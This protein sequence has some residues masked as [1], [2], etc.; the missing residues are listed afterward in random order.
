MK[1]LEGGSYR[2]TED[3]QIELADRAGKPG[4]KHVASPQLKAELAAA[5]DAAPE[6]E[7][8]DAGASIARKRRAS[9]S[10]E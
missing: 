2:Q 3:G 6:P 1:H 9:T 7:S 10:Q 5:A 8:A 4:A